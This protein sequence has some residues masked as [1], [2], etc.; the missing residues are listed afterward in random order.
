MPKLSEF[1]GIKIFMYWD[2]YDRHSV[3]HFHAVYNEHQASFKLNGDKIIGHF[4]ST[5]S[6]L[7]KKWAL[8]NHK[9]LKYAWKEALKNRPLPKIKG[10]V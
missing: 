8:A 3:P 9:I 6:K 7:V 10:L 1:Y 5:A 4:P 2:D